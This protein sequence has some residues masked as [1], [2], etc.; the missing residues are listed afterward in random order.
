MAQTGVS[1]ESPETPRLRRIKSTPHADNRGPGAGAGAKHQSEQSGQ[2]RHVVGDVLRSENGPVESGGVERHRQVGPVVPGGS[3]EGGLGDRLGREDGESGLALQDAVKVDRA[4]PGGLEEGKGDVIPAV[5][6][7][8]APG[9]GTRFR[10]IFPATGTARR[11]RPAR[12]L[13][14]LD[15]HGSGTVLVVDDDQG[16]REIA[17]DILE[18]AGLSVLCAEDAATGIDLF[19]RHVDEI[20]VVIL[21]RTMPGLGGEG[22]LDA[23]RRI[24][25]GTPVLLASGY[26]RER[27]TAQ[28]PGADLAGFLQKPFP[29]EVLLDAVRRA[30]EGK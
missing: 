6:I 1:G 11:D 16:V 30:I 21:D 28:L 5:E 24:R 23:I 27:A 17:R 12:P 15:W 4:V 9:R 10:V 14:A 8:S 7:E 19:A 22:T 13:A 2:I 29:P 20:R 26:S 18:R 25:S 3:S